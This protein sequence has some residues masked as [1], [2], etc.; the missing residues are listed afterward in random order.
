MPNLQATAL[1]LGV[2]AASAAQAG[3]SPRCPVGDPGTGCLQTV[4]D[5]QTVDFPLRH[6]SVD[7]RVSGPVARVEITQTFQNPYTETIEA[8]YVFPLPHD[9]A[10]SDFRMRVGERDI[11]GVI[12]RRDEARRIYEDARDRGHVASLL[13]QER[14]NIFTQSVANIVPGHEIHV[15]ITYVETL[16]YDRGRWELVF[17]TVVGPRFNPPGTPD[18]VPAGMFGPPRRS[19][20]PDADRINP[21]FLPPGVRS[22]QDLSIRVDWDAGIPIEA[23][24]SPTHRVKVTRKGERRAEIELHDLDTIPN[25]DFVLQCRAKGDGVGSGALAYHDGEDGFVTV[26]LHPKVDLGERDLTPREMIFVLDSSGSM[27]GEPIAAAKTVIRQALTHANPGDTFQMINFSSTASSLGPAPIPVTPENLKRG[28]AYLDR[29]EGEGGTMMIEGIKAALDFPHDPARLRVVMFLTDGYIGN[30]AEIFAA[31]RQKIGR[32]RL[33]SFGVGSCVN[34]YLLDGLAE[35]GRGEVQYVLPGSSA[36]EA[37]NR[38]EERVRN[39]YLTDVEL[40]WHGVRVED[41]SPARVPDLFG[42]STLAVHA[43]YE[44]AKNASV[45][46]RG[47]IAG[48]AWSKRIPLDLPSRRSGNEAVGALWAR[49]RI[50]DL[51]REAHTG[52]TAEIEDEITDLGLAHRLVTRFTSFV[53]VEEKTVVSDGR[54]QKVQVPVEMPQGVSWEGVFGRENEAPQAGMVMGNA[55]P[56]AGGFALKSLT[57]S[58]HDRASSVREESASRPELR[59]PATP[60]RSDRPVGGALAL[61]VSV[62]PNAVRSGESITLTVTIEN[63]GSQAVEIPKELRFGE[64]LLRLRVTDSRG[65]IMRLGAAA[66]G[67]PSISRVETVSLG[68]GKKHTFKVRITAAE[69]ELLRRAGRYE[70]VVDGGTLGSSSDSNAVTLEVLR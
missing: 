25:K 53:A 8:T 9:A 66:A 38:F 34:R 11:R 26:L 56:Q 54:P 1:A 36:M 60:R 4:I 19:S 16:P 58:G 43:R 21:P 24:E 33:Y 27:S 47:R 55:A 32:A 35:E 31:V 63:R 45:E 39:P 29:L 44:D 49:S 65:N 68:A 42:G 51:E 2:L 70:I 64:G 20:V 50:A 40:V 48:R 62:T 13:E 30:E 67:T 57:K 12:E 18:I 46:V 23:I 10:V 14:P 69:A 5:G 41:A 37:A 52:M 6:T 7:A 22:T 28:L 3:E 17:P 61:A 59:S 15:T